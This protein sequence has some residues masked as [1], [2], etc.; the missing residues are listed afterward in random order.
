MEKIFDEYQKLSLLNQLKILRDLAI[1][2]KDKNDEEI[3]D[4]HIMILQN[5]YTYNYQCLFEEFSP[6]MTIEECELVWDILDL[7]C[8]IKYSYK[9]IENSSIN[10]NDIYFKGFDG[11]NEI[12]LLS[13]CKF[14]MFNLH[15]FCELTE[16]GRTD[17]NSHYEMYY[18]YTKMIDKWAKMNK[19][20]DLSENQ[21][22]DILDL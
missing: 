20:Y 18:K 3:Y 2:R 7:Y 16:N 17:F 6:D 21:I 13:Y 4:N 12:Q 11:N 14:I 22:K 10:E 8:A 5:G 15:R 9:R 1:L 19:P